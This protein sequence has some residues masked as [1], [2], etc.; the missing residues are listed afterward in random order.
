MLNPLTKAWLVTITLVSRLQT[1]GEGHIRI[2]LSLQYLGFAAVDNMWKILET[3][4]FEI[5]LEVYF[6]RTAGKNSSVGGQASF[7]EEPFIQA[8][9]LA[10]RSLYV[11]K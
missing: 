8:A 1:D 10:V 2:H 11:D 6:E 4:W 5:D 3:T 7:S 9:L